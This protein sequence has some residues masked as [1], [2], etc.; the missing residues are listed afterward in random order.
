LAREACQV[1]VLAPLHHQAVLLVGT[2]LLKAGLLV[3][4]TQRRRGD[5]QQQGLAYAGAG[6]ELSLHQHLAGISAA[7][8]LPPCSTSPPSPFLPPPRCHRESQERSLS[9]A[10]RRD[11]FSQQG[12]RK[13]TP[14]NQGARSQTHGSSRHRGGRPL[15]S[16]NA[17]T[18]C[19]GGQFRSSLC[20]SGRHN[21]G[22]EDRTAF[23]LCRNWKVPR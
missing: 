21:I 18:S 17:T 20:A 13:Q 22:P 7:R 1:F 8:G 14:T 4:V 5:S 15:G 10:L 12:R 19:R 23:P 2:L 16:H 11:G 9:S 3:S 6:P